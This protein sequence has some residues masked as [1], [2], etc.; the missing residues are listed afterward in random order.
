MYGLNFFLF[1]QLH[2]FHLAIDS[3]MFIVQAGAAVRKLMPDLVGKQFYHCFE[4]RRPRLQPTFD[5]IQQAKNAAFLLTCNDGQISL[6]GQ[7]LLDEKRALLFLSGRQSARA[8]RC[9]VVTILLLVI[10]R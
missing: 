9:F 1:S 7:M 2:P 5:A 8:P 4:L 6:K 10:F 3:N